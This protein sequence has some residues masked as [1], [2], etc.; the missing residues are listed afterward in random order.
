MEN[1]DLLLELIE[2]AQGNRTQNSFALNCGF[3][4]SSISKIRARRVSPHPTLLQKIA[5]HAHNGV[6]YEQLM[7]AAGYLDEPSSSDTPSAYF[8]PSNEVSLGHLVKM[9][10]IGCISAGYD[11][12]AVEDIIDEFEVPQRAMRGYPKEDCFVLKVKG[13]SMYPDYKDKD[14]IL[15]HRQQSVDSGDV[16]VMLYNGDEATIKKVNYKYGEDWMELEPRNP[17]FQTKRI[18]GADL[19]ECR[20]LGKV[21]GIVW[22]E[23]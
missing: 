17:E 21:L 22:R 20:V 18:E 6:T 9:P 12:V 8:H 14:F 5:S 1:I 13:D 23:V 2:K 19:E 4:S 7:V 10:V 3:D 16:A 15:V 11:G